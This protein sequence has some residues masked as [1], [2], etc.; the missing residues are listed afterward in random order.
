MAV[1]YDLVVIGSSW[2]GIYAA[3]KAVQLQARVALVT[4]SD[5]LFLPNDVLT[6]SAISQVGR[7]N[8]Q[9][10]NHPLTKVADRISLTGRYKP[11][12]SFG[13]HV[14]TAAQ[15]W[16][17]SISSTIQHQNSLANLAAL[18]VDVI[19][20]Q[21]AFC[22]EPH[23]AF[24]T[25]H[26]KLRSR[27]FVLA[28]G[29]NYV[30]EFIEQQDANDYLTLRE[31]WQTDLT[32]LGQNIIIVGGDPL[33]LQLAQTL[34]RFE[35]TVTLVTAQPRI[36]PQEDLEFAFLL[37]AQLETEGVKLYLNSPISQLK[38]LEGQK[39]LQAGDRALTADQVIMAEHRQPNI[40][41]LNLAAVDVKYNRHRV[42]VNRK[43]QTSNPHIYACGDIIGGYS[44][45]NIARYEANLILKNTLWLPWYQVNYQA[46]PWVISTQPTFARVGL[47]TQQA[48]KQYGDDL[49]LVT[50]YFQELERSP[51][52]DSATGM[53]KLLITESG[54]IVGCSLIGD[55]AEELITA[56]ALMMQHKIKLERNPMK[57]LTSLA[58]P[59]TYLSMSEIWQRVWD[60]YYQQKLQRQP[61][62]LKRL[63]SWFSFRKQ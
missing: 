14:L 27:A 29:A 16:S 9:L 6:N 3:Q 5:D 57:G 21:G 7:W 18:G 63:R 55:R 11:P 20:G 46:L 52:A 19:P 36:L 13:G 1:D 37:Q 12:N 30:A 60:N 42:Y 62:L 34:A 48:Q 35:K 61:R 53:C 39:W 58:L 2:V 8:Y 17:H 54:E 51:M 59:T 15:D 41:G 43:L 44:L 50:E 33:A 24:Q 32:S 28:T 40:A 49:Y 38:T 47:T 25:A 31:L 56:I 10:A 22:P 4:S 26:R 23:L 45:P